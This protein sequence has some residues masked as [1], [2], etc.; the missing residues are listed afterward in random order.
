MRLA[1][2][3][4]RLDCQRKQPLLAR[5][6]RVRVAFDSLMLDSLILDETDVLTAATFNDGCLRSGSV[7]GRVNSKS[8]I[9]WSLH[10]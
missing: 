5:Q 2:E 10:E 3:V 6:Q 1:S 8:P 4:L 7:A 9:G